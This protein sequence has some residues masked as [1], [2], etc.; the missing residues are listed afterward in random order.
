LIEFYD[1]DIAEIVA[2]GNY[3]HTTAQRYQVETY[4]GIKYGMTLP[5]NYVATNGTTVWNVAANSSYNSNIIGIGRDDNGSLSQK[6]SKSTSLVQDMLTLYVGGAKVTDQSA[7]T[8][9]FASDRSFFMVGNNSAA[10]TYPFGSVVPVPA[11]ICCRLQ[12]QWMVQKTNFTNAD[13]KIEFDFNVISPGYSPLNTTDLRLLVD[14]DGNFTNATIL[15]SPAITISVSGSVVTVTIPASNFA[16]TSYFTLASVSATTLLPV[17]ISGFTGVCKNDAVQ[18]KWIKESGPDNSFTVERSIDGNNFTALGTLQSDALTPQ[19][20]TWS[21][22]DP[23]PGVGYY[24]LKMTSADGAAAYSGIASVNGCTHNGLQLTSDAV[25]G[26]STLVMQLSQNATVDISFC[27]MLGRQYDISNLT[28]HRS[29]QQGYY[30]LPVA[31]SH[32]PRGVY[33]LTVGINGSRSVFRIVK[34]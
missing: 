27:D 24:R 10:Y 30:R 14:G 15:N 20:Y 9:T 32:L 6:Q 5:H 16:A 28:G 2:F 33:V 19:T 23:L 13:L 22:K 1:G 3:S 31:D 25:S 17:D 4:L 29:M 21:D 11:G 12:R 26:Q 18:L 7:N 34:Q 8:G